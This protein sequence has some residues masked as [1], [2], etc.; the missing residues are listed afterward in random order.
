MALMVVIGLGITFASVVDLAKDGLH[1]A[2]VTWIVIGSLGMLL[3]VVAL[4]LRQISQMS[5]IAQK[6]ERPAK[7]KKG[8]TEEL[9]P[10]ELPPARI[11]PMPSV[12][13][14]TTRT[15]EPAVKGRKS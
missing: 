6:T 3:G 8:A 15:F 14:H 10:P 12:T 11:N 13:E 1:P 9:R 5:G 2:A 4:F 7:R